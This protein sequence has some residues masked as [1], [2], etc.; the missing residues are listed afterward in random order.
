MLSLR[1]RSQTR[2][3]I[4]E[5][6]DLGMLAPT[7]RDLSGANPAATLVQ[8]DGRTVTAHDI[9]HRPKAPFVCLARGCLEQR[10][11]DAAAALPRAH[12]QPGND[13]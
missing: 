2:S 7:D 5:L 11:A 4:D 1:R 10:P 13:T 12:E 6:L 9:E 3:E 8:R